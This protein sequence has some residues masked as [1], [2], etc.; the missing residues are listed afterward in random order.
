MGLETAHP[1][2]LARLNKGMTRD[3][4]RRAAA[5]LAERG[6]ALRVFLLAP[7][8]FVPEV[9]QAEWM[10]RSVDFAFDCGASA[11]SLV[12]LRT[13]SGPA[14]ALAAWGLATAP[15]LRQLEA[16]LASALAH[17][18]GR[19]R[20]FVDLWDLER[21]RGEEGF[22]SCRERLRQMNLEQVVAG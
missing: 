8:P 7:A 22:G 5:G 13:E 6:V 10:L 15:R 11:V 19:G 4:F 12:P 17:A 21:F 20:V 1:D 16:W 14:H 2:A 18:S 3:S 9:E